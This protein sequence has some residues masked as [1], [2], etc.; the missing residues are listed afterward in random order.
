MTDPADVMCKILC[1][2]VTHDGVRSTLG[3]IGQSLASLTVINP[4]INAS[5]VCPSSVWGSRRL[6][7]P[8]EFKHMGAVR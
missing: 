8:W 1:K 5:P 2:S 6:K 4:Q 3:Q 7:S